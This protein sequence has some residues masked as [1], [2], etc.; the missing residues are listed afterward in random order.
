[1]PLKVLHTGDVHLGMTFRNRNYPQQLREALVKARVEVLS[2]LVELANE[3]NCQLFLVAGDL[4][5]RTNVSQEYVLSAL[6]ILSSFNGGCVAV[7][8]GNHDFFDEYSPLWKTM[9]EHAFDHLLILDQA[10][11]YDLREFNLNLALYPAPCNSKHSRENRVGWLKECK[12]KPPVKWHLGAAHGTVKGVS[13]DTE[14]RYFP[15]EEEELRQMGLHHWCL[16]HIHARYPDLD[17]V[18]ESPFTY[19]GTPEPDGFDCTHNGFARIISLDDNGN[20]ESRSYSTG[21]FRFE[22]LKLEMS[23]L[24]DMQNLIENWGK[25]AEHTLLKLKLSGSLSREEYYNKGE[26][27]NALMDSFAYVELDDS[28]LTMQ[29]TPE[30]ISEEF[31][32]GSFPHLLLSRLAQ[33]E[34]TEALQMAYE[35][36]REVKGE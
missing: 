9:R 24:K 2:R 13:P 27:Y 34:E 3:E 32:E 23:D 35:F 28:E 26:V 29:I 36:I 18:R 15:M 30:V 7:M 10:A 8:P 11:P 25:K 21:R 16:G 33:R 19:P 6:E 12:D 17:I 31:R 22:E 20:F 14:L 5:H 1:M 4:F